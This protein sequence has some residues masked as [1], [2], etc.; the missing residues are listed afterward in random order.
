MGK[1]EKKRIAI[2]A[3]I[4]ASAEFNE[5]GNSHTFQKKYKYIQNNLFLRFKSYESAQQFFISYPNCC[6]L[7]AAKT[8]LWGT[9]GGEQ[10]NYGAPLESRLK[11]KFDSTLV[12]KFPNDE[13]RVVLD[14][15][16][17]PIRSL[18]CPTK[19]VH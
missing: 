19:V 17:Q 9:Y 1:N 13:E 11:G 7:I 8:Y 6:E 5:S 14:N 2:K 3:L 15:C 10:I 4:D 18:T 12:I 16:G